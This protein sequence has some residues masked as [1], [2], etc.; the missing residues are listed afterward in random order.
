MLHVKQLLKTKGRKFMP[1]SNNKKTKNQD[2]KLK[3][4]VL[5]SE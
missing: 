4:N 2:L 3:M 5:R 1:I